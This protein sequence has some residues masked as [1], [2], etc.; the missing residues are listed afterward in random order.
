MDNEDIMNDT[1]LDF[2]RLLW[3]SKAHLRQGPSFDDKWNAIR[4]AMEGHPTLQAWLPASNRRLL[5]RF[6]Q[7]RVRVCL[8]YCVYKSPADSTGQLLPLPDTASEIEK[9]VYRMLH[10]N[11]SLRKVRSAMR[12]YKTKHNLERTIKS[13]DKVKDESSHSIKK[14]PIVQEIVERKPTSEPVGVVNPKENNGS[15]SKHGEGMDCD[16]TSMNA[17]ASERLNGHVGAADLIWKH[18][19]ALERALDVHLLELLCEVHRLNS[20][21]KK[22]DT[23][24]DEAEDWIAC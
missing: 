5:H 9:I 19:V 1:S 14:K 15:N 20:E 23:L 16:V 22:L 8:K 24:L 11:P 13:L 12:K 4:Q 18:L 6:Q 3:R 7:L 21:E 17:I 10:C 2:L